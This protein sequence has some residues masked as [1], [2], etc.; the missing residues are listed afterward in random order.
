KAHIDDRYFDELPLKPLKG[1][2]KIGSIRRYKGQSD[3]TMGHIDLFIFPMINRDEDVAIISEQLDGVKENRLFDTRCIFIAGPAGCGRS[4]LLDHVHELIMSEYPTIRVIVHHASFEN[5]QIPG[6]VLKQLFKILLLTELQDPDALL[7]LLKS[8]L[9]HYYQYL[10]LIRQYFDKL[11]VDNFKN[12]TNIDFKVMNYGP[13]QTVFLIDDAQYLDIESWQYIT[14]LGASPTSLVIMAMREMSHDENS[15]LNTYIANVRESETTK[16]IHFM[17]KILLIFDAQPPSYPVLISI[18]SEFLDIEGI[19]EYLW[20][21]TIQEDSIG[22]KHIALKFAPDQY[23]RILISDREKLW[24][25]NLG[26][27][28]IHATVKIDKL[29]DFEKRIAK[30]SSLI[31]TRISKRIIVQAL[32]GI[33]INFSHIA[34]RNYIGKISINTQIELTK[35]NYAFVHLYRSQIFECAWME[36]E[37]K[38][39]PLLT[40]KKGVYSVCCCPENVTKQI[41]NCLMFT[42]KEAALKE[43]ALKILVESF[44]YEYTTKMA[45]FLESKPHFCK[46]CGGP[47][48]LVFL[49][50][51]QGVKLGMTILDALHERQLKD[52]KNRLQK[53]IYDTFY[54]RQRTFRPTIDTNPLPSSTFL[55]PFQS[56]YSS[57]FDDDPPVDTVSELLQ[58]QEIKSVAKIAEGIIINGSF[59]LSKPVTIALVTSVNDLSDMEDYEKLQS[60]FIKS[61]EKN[62]FGEDTMVEEEITQHIQMENPQQ[63]QRK[64]TDFLNQYHHNIDETEKELNETFFRTQREVFKQVDKY[65]QS[66]LSLTPT[67]DI[68]EVDR[69]ADTENRFTFQKLISHSDEQR[70]YHHPVEF[71]IPQGGSK[72]PNRKKHFIEQPP[73][74]KYS[75]LKQQIGKLITSQCNVSRIM[76]Q[77]NSNTRV[78][79]NVPSIESSPHKK[80]STTHLFNVNVKNQSYSP[81]CQY[82]TTSRNN[83]YRHSSHSSNSSLSNEYEEE[84]IGNK[85]KNNWHIMLIRKYLTQENKGHDH[86]LKKT[87]RRLFEKRFKFRKKRSKIATNIKQQKSV[88][89]DKHTK[90]PK[91]ENDDFFPLYEKCI[92]KQSSKNNILSTIFDTSLL[93]KSSPSNGQHY[94][95]ET[96]SIQSP[97]GYHLFN[98]SQNFNN[99]YTKE[100]EYNLDEIMQKMWM[101]SIHKSK[102]N[103]QQPKFN[104]NNGKTHKTFANSSKYMSN[105][106]DHGDSSYKGCSLNAADVDYLYSIDNNDHELG[107]R[108][109][110]TLMNQTNAQN[111]DN[112]NYQHQNYSSEATA[113]SRDQLQYLQQQQLVQ[114]R[115]KHP[116]NT[117]GNMFI[118]IACPRNERMMG[119]VNNSAHPSDTQILKSHSTTT[120]GQFSHWPSDPPLNRLPF[121]HENPRNCTRTS[122]IISSPQDLLE[123]EQLTFSPSRLSYFEKITNKTP[124]SFSIGAPQ[125]LPRS[126][127][128]TYGTEKESDEHTPFI[129]PH[130]SMNKPSLTNLIDVLPLSKRNDENIKDNSNLGQNHT[131][132]KT[133]FHAHLNTA[134]QQEQQQPVRKEKKHRVVKRTNELQMKHSTSTKHKRLLTTDIMSEAE[135][136]G[137]HLRLSKRNENSKQHH[138]S[139]L[140]STND[141]EYSPTYR[142][143]LLEQEVPSINQRIYLDFT[144]AC[145]LFLLKEGIDH[146]FEFLDFVPELYLRMTFHPIEDVELISSHSDRDK[147]PELSRISSAFNTK[148]S[149]TEYVEY[150]QRNCRCNF[151]LTEVYRL[152]IKLWEQAGHIEK[153]L[154]Y[155]LQLARVELVRTNYYETKIILQRIIERFKKDGQNLMLPSFFEPQIYDLLSES[156]YRMYKNDEAFLYVMYGLKIL[157]IQLM[158]FRSR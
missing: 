30:I 78:I 92:T 139:A 9:G 109:S 76:V 122:S 112:L 44:I 12:T 45:R 146:R 52:L 24:S 72:T 28:N 147:N 10:Y 15:E 29:F 41:E 107:S 2:D 137:K 125:A 148:V 156:V 82:S 136:L 46:S 56:Q 134:K 32:T 143:T 34:H 49:S 84:S 100:E 149:T 26:Y 68:T 123:Y 43:A 108:Q 63:E 77:E 141:E 38:R 4:R 111:G 17:G 19:K 86:S 55:R 99:N 97:F 88:I 118:E 60:K 73:I 133:V 42:F 5:V 39:N 126:P 54:N 117:T 64:A 16:Y 51:V 83:H 106:N 18:C 132:L 21:R 114:L 101:K 53:M 138:P 27:E 35:I 151:L 154:Y 119:L 36:H 102:K 135:H 31:G 103:N 6:Y 13:Q 113:I 89:K 158:D 71:T 7:I 57:I 90:S 22:R 85:R 144:D 67:T 130:R 3:V 128:I 129:I 127:L 75:L 48:L 140:D 87:V 40:E 58:A 142:N 105:N 94:F 37:A 50:P 153:V 120:S 69:N 115:E 59:L 70:H 79:S 91:L 47:D 145:P 131:S 11:N 116:I 20:K 74:K 33:D 62:S 80:Y 65:Y 93:S 14:L 98:H 110:S 25:S 66:K 23:C 150:N 121:L 124:T 104:N 81:Y 155:S 8:L 95:N 61:F 1:L 152:L 96:S 157:N